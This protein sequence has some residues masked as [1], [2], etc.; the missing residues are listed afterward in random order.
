LA[1]LSHEYSDSNNCSLLIMD[2]ATAPGPFA[3]CQVEVVPLTGA[4]AD[5]MGKIEMNHRRRLVASH[6]SP[7]APQLP[8]A[9]F[10]R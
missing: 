9:V 8:S 1:S 10:A 6:R 2:G 4:L 3:R 5:V 7:H